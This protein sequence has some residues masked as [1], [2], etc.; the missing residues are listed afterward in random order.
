MNPFEEND[1][2]D[3]GSYANA[4]L[5]GRIVTIAAG[6]LANYVFAT[7]F[8]FFGFLIGGNEVRDEMRVY[9]TTVEGPAARAG[10]VEGDNI[11]KVNDQPITDWDQ[12]KKAVGAHPGE[13]ID[14]EAERGGMIIHLHPVPEAS[15]ERK[16]MIL[17]GP[18]FKTVPVTTSEALF[19]SVKTPPLVVY[20]QL[21]GLARMLTRVEKPELT[22]PLGIARSVAAAVH[23]GAGDALKHL[24]FISAMLGAFNLLP[25]PALDGGRLLFLLFEA[26]SRRR[27]DAK[28]EAKVHAVGLLMFLTLIAV[29]TLSEI[30]R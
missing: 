8:F 2:E 23:S 3:A 6:P 28:V 14:V 17:I 19:L 13:A 30:R 27:A 7:V 4:S 21:S 29:V 18:K 12:L 10:F 1:P 20:D 16:G 25:V 11:L 5:W 22:G 9:P 15:G 24:G 26:L